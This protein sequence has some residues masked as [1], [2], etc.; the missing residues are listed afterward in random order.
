MKEIF[1]ELIKEASNG[2]VIIDNEEWPIAFNTIVN[3][4]DK[5]IRFVGN[6]DF[7]TLMINN[8]DEFLLHLTKY[9]ELEMK[10]K[11]KMPK[12]YYEEQKNQLKWLMSYI[13]VNATTEDFLNPILYIQR[14]INFL[15]DNTF[16]AFNDSIE[17]PLNETF[18]NGKLQIKNNISPVA[19]ETPF[20][21]SF[22]LIKIDCIHNF[23]TIYY[24]I[25]EENNE[26]V[27]YIYSI[28]QKKKEDNKSE[29]FSKKINRLLY[30]V[31]KNI[32][33]TESQDYLDYINKKSTYYPEE[34]ISDISPSFIFSLN[35]FLSLLQN[36][37]IQKIKVVTYLPLR[38]NSR[39]ISANQFSLRKKELLNRND[40]IQSNA[41]NKLIRTF[42][43]MIYHNKALNIVSFPY[44]IDEYLHL[45]LSEKKAE[46]NNMLLEEMN[47]LIEKESN[48]AKK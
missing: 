36:K 45:N 43:R 25:N 44:E 46:L 19:M 18:Y 28:I 7:D 1:Y 27:C 4:G 29:E 31:N 13:F 12:F 26:K 41:T 5:E 30:K 15:Q 47:I 2:K 39:F 10:N 16:E 34:N 6:K 22:N 9:L 14:I 24:G 21:I 37:N 8:Y 42:R 11:R 32:R 35:I 48:H 17:I 40:I 38:Y 33:E 23:P 3:D 20:N